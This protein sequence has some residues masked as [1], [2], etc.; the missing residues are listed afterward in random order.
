MVGV[1][2]L[3]PTLHAQAPA[4]TGGAGPGSAASALAWSI[5]SLSPAKHRQ[6]PAGP[7]V[8]LSIPAIDVSR[9]LLRLGV[10]RDRTV[11]VPSPAHAELPGWFRLGPTPGETGSAVILG[12]VDSRSGPAVF[13]RLRFL[14]S[15]D[16]VVVRRAGGT[17]SRFTVTKVVTYPNDEFP[18][19]KVYASHG[20][21]ALNLV[22]C[23]GAYDPDTGYQANVVVYTRLADSATARTASRS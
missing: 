2:W 16:H 3:A 10:N 17:V 14:E 11:Q 8:H 6:S 15:G 22:T 21:A 9:P 1:A 12:H 19:R 5:P 23:G 18:A 4:A 13:H 7:P 20:Y